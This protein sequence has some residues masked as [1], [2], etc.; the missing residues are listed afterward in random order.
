MKYPSMLFQKSLDYPFQ[1]KKRKEN[2][3]C[4]PTTILHEEA[5]GEKFT[6]LQCCST[7]AA[8]QSK[9]L[10]VN[11]HLS[12]SLNFSQTLSINLGERALQFSMIFFNTSSQK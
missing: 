9:S 8:S 12:A 4:Q 11:Q 1:K 7:A 6:V 10:P 5:N 3:Y 2:T